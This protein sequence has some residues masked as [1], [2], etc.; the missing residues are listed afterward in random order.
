M[1]KRRRSST[2]SRRQPGFLESRAFMALLIGSVGTMLLISA[3]GSRYGIP[4]ALVGLV[5][6]GT[7]PVVMWPSLPRLLVKW[8]RRRRARAA[9][10]TVAPGR[11]PIPAGLR[12][13]VLHRDG[14]RC[15][16]CGRGEPDGVKL[17]LD[18][19]VPVAAGGRSEIDNLVVACQDCN[20]GKSARD[21][22][23]AA[24]E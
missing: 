17:H 19:L 12:F 16:Y 4:Y 13:A 23:G 21:V 7:A 11:E 18:H 10:R 24:R 5:L 8:A 1:A 9:S 6:I 15:R 2:A 3:P 22:V 14:F 20:L